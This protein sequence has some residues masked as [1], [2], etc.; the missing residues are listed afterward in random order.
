MER[1]ADCDFEW[2]ADGRGFCRNCHHSSSLT[3]K[4]S[5]CRLDF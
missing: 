1:R 2:G 3:V 4:A 5:D